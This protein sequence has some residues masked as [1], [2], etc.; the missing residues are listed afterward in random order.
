M[1][2]AM[3]SAAP[4]GLSPLSVSLVMTLFSFF[5][6]TAGNPCANEDANH[7][8]RSEATSPRNRPVPATLAGPE[9]A[10]AAFARYLLYHPSIL[11]PRCTSPC[12]T[13]GLRS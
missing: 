3:V 13:S 9:N 7:R 10:E 6:Q 12:F 8:W 5:A 2:Q 4:C 11:Q 1:R